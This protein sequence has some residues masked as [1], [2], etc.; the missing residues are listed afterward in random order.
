MPRQA[1]IDVPGLYY[2]VFARGIEKKD[3]FKCES[4]KNFF[5]SRLGEVIQDTATPVYAFALMPNHFHLL[6]RRETVPIAT[7]MQKLLTGYAINFNKLYQRVGHL[8]QNRYKAIV[9][10]KESYL[11]EL[12][13]YINLNP[14]R[15]GQVRSLAEL[16]EYKFCSHSFI[17]G[18]HKAQWFDPDSV[19]QFFGNTKTEA[20]QF[21]AQ[22][23]VDGLLKINA[24]DAHIIS[25]ERYLGLEENF[26]AMDLK[27][28]KQTF[29]EESVVEKTIH[30]KDNYDLK[31]EEKESKIS[32][33]IADI[34]LSCGVTK[35]ELFGEKKER[36]IANARAV[37]AY[38]LSREVSLTCS[39][40]ACQLGV[41]PSA[42]FKM[43]KKGKRLGEN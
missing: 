3:I 11:L 20:A 39:E 2:H 21:Y 10:Q 29:G 17:L 13:R 31:S 6:L 25:L 22:L 40:V 4:D 14:L 18:E 43:I 9:C 28:I 16:N 34:C 26:T 35:E 23:I 27:V 30:L 12:I 38:K 42:A 7:V 41:T 8:F 19:L 15:S 36:K 1:R 33:L 32:S 5:L 24:P 37:L